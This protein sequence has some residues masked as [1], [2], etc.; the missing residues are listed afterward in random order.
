MAVY[1][2][3]LMNH[4]WILRGHRVESCHMMA[5]TEE[6]LHLFAERLG[7]KRSWLHRDHYD[8]VASKRKKAIELGAV[9]CN[10]MESF[11]DKML[12]LRKKRFRPSPEL[13]EMCRK[14]VEKEGDGRG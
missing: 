2:D 11:R 13:Q 7:M 5:D 10:D 4:G 3:A 1:V 8:L 9:E 14:I 6:E 12:P